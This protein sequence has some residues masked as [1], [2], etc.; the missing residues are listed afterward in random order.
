M[1]DCLVCSRIEQIRR[2]EN[3][4]FV[5][6]LS[7]GYVVLGDYQRFPGYTLFL[8][9]EHASE[10]HHLDREFRN[11]FLDEMSLTA[12]AV[13]RAFQPEKLNYELLGRGMLS[14]CTGISSRVKQG[15][16]PA[17]ALYGG[18]PLKK[19]MMRS[20][21]SQPRSWKTENGS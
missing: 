2:G 13:Y 4:Y 21:A 20:T 17:E 8:C 19:C 16:F 15:M 11:R 5:E 3:P 10:L 12:E 6:E 18:F 14:I 7:T 9:K 1:C